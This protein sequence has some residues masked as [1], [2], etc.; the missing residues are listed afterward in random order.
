MRPAQHARSARGIPQ[1]ALITLN[2]GI[3]RLQRRA[4]RLAVS[5]N[6]SLR[7]RAA[8]L[9]CRAVA[10][11]CHAA[12]WPD[13]HAGQW[14]ECSGRSVDGSTGRRTDVA[15]GRGIV[16][17]TGRGQRARPAVR[18]RFDG[19]VCC[20]RQVPQAIWEKPGGLPV[21]IARRIRRTEELLSS[22]RCHGPLMFSVGPIV[23]GLVEARP[24]GPGRRRLVGRGGRRCCSPGVLLRNVGP[25]SRQA[26]HRR[27]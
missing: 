27:G 24:R 3:V 6:T 14:P 23:G 15:E 11:E 12:R 17:S 19:A 13:C 2:A 18:R 26:E 5:N 8:P 21:C 20:F 7:H 10:R 9:R 25:R 1:R 22:Q 4:T 16:G